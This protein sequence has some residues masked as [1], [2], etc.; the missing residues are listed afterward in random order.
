MRIIQIGPAQ[1]VNGV[2]LLLIMKIFKDKKYFL[3]VAQM[4]NIVNKKI[5]GKKYP[6]TL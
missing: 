4:V 3:A 5:L 2:Q 6:A 1:L